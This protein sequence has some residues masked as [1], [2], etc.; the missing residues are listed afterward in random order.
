MKTTIAN[1]WHLGQ[2]E[3]LLGND[4]ITNAIRAIHDANAYQ[5]RINKLMGESSIHNALNAFNAANSYQENINKLMG[6]SSI[7]SALNAFN[8]ANSYQERINK[9]MGGGALQSAIKSINESTAHQHL[10]EELLTRSSFQNAVNAF[11]KQATLGNIPDWATHPIGPIDTHALPD[12]YLIDAEIESKLAAIGE[13]GDSDSTSFSKAF[14]SLPAWLQLILL[15]ILVNLFLPV[16]QNIIANLVTPH[17]EKIFS[18]PVKTEKEKK[19]QS[20]A[21]SLDDLDLSNHRFV[22]T[23]RLYLRESPDSNSGILSELKLGQVVSVIEKDRNWMKVSCE[24]EDGII[25]QGWVFSRYMEKFSPNVIKHKIP[26]HK[27]RGGLVDGLN[28]LSN[29]AML[30]AA[31]NDA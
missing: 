2:I 5:E 4:A 10:I 12:P 23:A 28:P 1:N 3:K 15:S 31:D 22:S 27:G 9:L 16:S 26:V 24:D 19:E 30:D 25:V 7:Q 17:I 29:K 6:V 11:T 8:A 14:E 20:K 21:F 18:D 13:A